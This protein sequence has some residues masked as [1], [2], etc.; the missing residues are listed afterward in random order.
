MSDK[1]SHAAALEPG[2]RFDCGVFIFGK[3][4]GDLFFSAHLSSVYRADIH[5]SSFLLQRR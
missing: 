3:T 1:A 2:R 5:P 4:Q